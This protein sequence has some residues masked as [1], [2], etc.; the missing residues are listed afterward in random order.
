MVP[1]QMALAP[2]QAP[3]S[4]PG[5]TL[6]FGWVMPWRFILLLGLAKTRKRSQVAQWSFRLVVAA[7]FIAGSL[8]VLGCGVFSEWSIVYR[9][10]HGFDLSCADSHFEDHGTLQQ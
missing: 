3:H 4:V 6:A 9:D 1:V 8:W 2:R 5:G 10:S 7:A